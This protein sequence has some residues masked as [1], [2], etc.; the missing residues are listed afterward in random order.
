VIAGVADHRGEVV[1]VID[2]RTRF[3]LPPLPAPQRPKWIVIDVRSRSVALIV[4]RVTEVFGTGGAELRPPPML[5]SGDDAR[6]ISGVTTHDRQL[7][8]VLDVSR[9]ETL[10]RP[11]AES[12]LIA[13]AER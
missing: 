6:G 12:E 10:T 3:G 7:T 2:L 8:F 1:P 13:R 11:F 5:G 4:D 9:F